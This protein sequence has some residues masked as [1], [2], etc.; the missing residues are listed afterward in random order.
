MT[1]T[2]AN[3]ITGVFAVISVISGIV[4]LGAGG[5]CVWYF[6]PRNGVPH[7]LARKPLLDAMIPISI[8]ASLAVGVALI[9]SGF[10]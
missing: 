2:S 7:P 1:M 9:V 8:V 6:I 10:A 4:V 5:T 3:Q